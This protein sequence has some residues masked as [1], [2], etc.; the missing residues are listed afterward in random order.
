MQS[1]GVLFEKITPDRKFV[2]R[3]CLWR[4]WQIRSMGKLFDTWKWGGDSLSSL[5]ETF[6]LN[7]IYCQFAVD[8]ISYKTS[9]QGHHNLDSCSFGD[10]ARCLANRRR[11]GRQSRRLCRRRLQKWAEGAG[12]RGSPRL[13]GFG[14][15]S[16]LLNLATLLVGCIAGAWAARSLR[17]TPPQWRGRSWWRSSRCQSSWHMRL[18]ASSVRFPRSWKHL[19]IQS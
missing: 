18:Q 13:A 9:M 6:Q 19:V 12:G 4:L 17:A 5:T 2:H 7:W 1:F 11:R 8:I 14:L 10:S 16:P 3:R 15:P